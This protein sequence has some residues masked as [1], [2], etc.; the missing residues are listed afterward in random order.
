[1]KFKDEDT[2]KLWYQWVNKEPVHKPFLRLHRTLLIIDDLSKLTGHGEITVT[3]FLRP[4]GSGGY[5][6]E[7]Q[8]ADF[9]VKD[10]SKEWYEAMILFKYVLS[11]LDWQVQLVPHLE[12]WRKDHQ[13]I[14]VEIDDGSLGHNN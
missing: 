2:G 1:M 14:H 11:R 3:E 5:H 10:K 6:P 13:H 9:R 7:A 4:K 12:L 8:A